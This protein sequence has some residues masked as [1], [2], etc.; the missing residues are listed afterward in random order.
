MHSERPIS[1]GMLTPGGGIRRGRSIVMARSNSTNQGMN[2]IL[3][4][5]T[6]LW[7]RW[8]VIALSLGG[9]FCKHG[10]NGGLLSLLGYN[11]VQAQ[12]LPGMSKREHPRVNLFC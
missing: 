9:R 5:L 11:R 6:E 7:R 8:I 1:C 2:A 3:A 4:W 10:W 12:R